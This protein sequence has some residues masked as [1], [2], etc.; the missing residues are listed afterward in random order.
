[1]S[2]QPDSNQAVAGFLANA[3]A[4]IVDSGSSSRPVLRKMLSDLGVKV[5]N[6]SVVESFEA[7]LQ[8]MEAQQPSVVF[9]DHLLGQRTAVD[10]F[11][12]YSRFVPGRLSSLFIVISGDNS[13]VT[14]TTL[15]DADVDAV[16]VKP[17]NIKD[18]HEKFMEVVA[19]KARPSQYLKVLEAGM[20]FMDSGKHEQALQAFRSAHRHD[21]KPAKACYLEG[22]AQKALG[23]LG[24]ALACFKR[25]LEH[26]PSHYR[27]LVG[28]FEL[29]VEQRRNAEAYDAGL[30][31]LAHHPMH[32]KRIPEM[33]RLCIVT[34]R[35]PEVRRFAETAL[36]ISLSDETISK[37]VTAGLFI[38]GKYLLKRG[39]HQE[40][41][42]VLRKTEK[43]SRERPK[44]LAE[45]I[46]ALYIA[47]LE[48]EAEEMLSRAPSEI[49]GSKEVRLAILDGLHAKGFDAK[50]F[51]MGRQLIQD[52][53]V[54]FRLFEIV[55]LQAKGLNRPDGV[56]QEILSLACE[57]L[58]D[59]KG[60][61]EAILAQAASAPPAKAAS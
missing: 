37:Y 14:L 39:E 33:I 3:R 56:I 44:V 11:R 26:D 16:L 34:E 35:F 2:D 6:V 12:E 48:K 1:M 40:A 15:A 4:L 9:T 47:G 13:P 45:I 57:A 20:R 59:N 25:G 38:C 53:L 18:L 43:L 29:L 58:P 30:A 61:F 10:I 46:A 17:L 55:L 22:V 51:F 31:I 8:A 50:T 7:A 21:A 60:Q 54:S 24:E 36:E 41:I 27:C 32:P 5:S 23:D 49:A 42:E 52:G 19:V 28:V